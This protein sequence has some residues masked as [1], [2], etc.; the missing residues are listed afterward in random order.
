[1]A[2]L[3]THDQDN[4]G[5]LSLDEFRAWWAEAG[6][7]QQEAVDVKPAPESEPEPELK[8][9]PEPEP[10]PEM[11]KIVDQSTKVRTHWRKLRTQFR[12]ATTTLGGGGGSG[13]GGG[14]DSV[15]GLDEMSREQQL[16]ACRLA[17]C[18]IE[19]IVPALHVCA[20]L[21]CLLARPFELTR[22]A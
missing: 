16:E 15:E 17:G 1:M 14:D 6:G 3:A 12:S 2:T 13:R 21:G 19:A 10:E 4:N 8:P 20:C 22:W 11:V 9:E 18:V 5:S 7:A